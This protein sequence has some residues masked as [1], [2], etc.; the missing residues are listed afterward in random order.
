MHSWKEMVKNNFDKLI[1]NL[2]HTIRMFSTRRMH[3]TEKVVVINTY[4]LSKLWYISQILPPDNRQMAEI[5]MIVGQFL[6]SHHKMFRVQ[7]DQLYLDKTLGGLALIDPETQSQSL[8]IRNLLFKND[9]KID[10]P[11][12]NMTKFKNLTANTKK[13]FSSTQLV[14]N[15]DYIITNKHIYNHLLAKKTIE[16]KIVQKHP[17]LPWE[18]I[19]ENITKNCISSQASSCLYEIFN[20][21]YPNKV[22][23]FN[24][25]FANIDNCLCD[26][27]GEPDTNIH[28]IKHC[29][30]SKDVWDWVS[31]VIKN[32][33]RLKLQSVDEIIHR[34][35]NNKDNRGKSAL[36]LVSEMIV[37]NIVVDAV[38]I[39][40]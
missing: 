3:L 10:H 40:N 39:V 24:H 11:L 25:N 34:R 31:D 14:H 32:K 20:D 1:S 17:N 26:V 28:R 37:Y 30:K 8:F 38:R 33:I 21:V 29:K 9:V 23:M 19:W 16:V 15:L 13:L 5:K 6:W 22:K 12:R 36:W 35:V 18:V 7:R 4:V 2:K 27:C